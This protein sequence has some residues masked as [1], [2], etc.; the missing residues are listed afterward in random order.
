MTVIL[1]KEAEAFVEE[2]AIEKFHGVG[3]VT[4]A[5]MRSLGILTGADLK[6]R[7]RE[8]RRRHR[9]NIWCNLLAKRVIITTTLLALKITE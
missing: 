1:P 3:K 8:P 9:L 5:K 2:L 4:A 6:E 7:L